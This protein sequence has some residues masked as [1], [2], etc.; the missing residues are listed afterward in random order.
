MLFFWKIKE[1]TDIALLVW[2]ELIKTLF[3]FFFTLVSIA[4]I[5]AVLM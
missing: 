2:F 1:L 5:F 3:F 4:V